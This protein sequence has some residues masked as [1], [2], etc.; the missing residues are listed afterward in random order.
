[1]WKKLVVIAT[2]DMSRVGGYRQVGVPI[3]EN[4]SYV[5]NSTSTPYRPRETV[6]FTEGERY[7]AST[8]HSPAR[9]L[10]T[11]PSVA[12]FQPPEPSISG[13]LSGA[14]ARPPL[15]GVDAGQCAPR[16][17]MFRSADARGSAG[18]SLSGPDADHA[19]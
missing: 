6:A 14:S 12:L 17:Q 19:R 4:G 13:D 1:M 15:C 16:P 5:D 10:A 8:V 9:G 3:T 7:A 11:A 2:S 18:H